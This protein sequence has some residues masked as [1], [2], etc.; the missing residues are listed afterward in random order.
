[1]KGQSSVEFLA[2][3]G[4]AMILAAPFI[5][6]AQDSAIN[7]RLGTEAAEFSSSFDDLGGAI[8]AVAAMGEPAKRT[9]RLDVPQGIESATVVSNQALVYTQSRGDRSS[10]YTS[11]HDVNLYAGDLPTERGSYE[12]EVE[13]W[14]NQVNLTRK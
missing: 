14:N 3:I 8:D 11:I 5:V 4:M 9:V 7:L 12:I 1:M 6:Q 13:A 10:N 2:I